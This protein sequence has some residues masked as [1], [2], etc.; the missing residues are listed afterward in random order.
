[1]VTTD[2]EVEKLVYGGDGLSRFEGQVVLTPFVLAGER[3]TADIDKPKQG[4]A[5][6]KAIEITVAS[7]D[8]VKPGCEYFGRCGGCHYQHA[9]YEAQKAAKVS[10]LRET[11]ERV[12]KLKELPEIEVIAGEPWGYRNRAQLHVE[13]GKLGYLERGSHKL[14]AIE[15]CPISSPTIN[16]AIASLNRM[17]KDRRW[18]K[19][20]RSLEVFTNEANVQVN[21]LEYDQPVAKRFFEWCA[22]EIPGLVTEPIE[23]GR[24]RVS[25]G[26]FFQSNRFLAERMAEYCLTG[27]SGKS[28]IDLYAGVGLFTLPMAERFEKV[29]AVETGTGAIRDLEFNA[30]RAGFD[31]DTSVGNVDEYLLQRENGADF[32]LADPPRT[33]LGKAV[34]TRLNALRV[35]KMV[36]VSCDPATLARDLAALSE[37][38]LESLALMDLF[39]QT[40]HIETVAKLRLAED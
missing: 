37:Y 38:K 23:Y 8:R 35:Q 22:E 25:H 40:F 11:L 3:M 18:P 12:G 17:L 15:R 14:C 39:P 20:I 1:M 33:G 31:I 2:L 36:L 6:G 32:V 19:F 16:R 7:A 21:I 13:N 24:F 30:K 34:T 10:I 28:A 26:S 4:V 27:E 5:R 29:M 9:N